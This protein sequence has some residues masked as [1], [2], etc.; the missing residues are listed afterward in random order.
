MFNLPL[1]LALIGLEKIFL[2]A[3]NGRGTSIPHSICSREVIVLF[4]PKYEL[5]SILN[6]M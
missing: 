3:I 5:L 1:K 2:E 6:A 4:L